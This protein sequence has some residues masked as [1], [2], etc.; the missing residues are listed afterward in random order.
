MVDGGDVV[1]LQNWDHLVAVVGA[2]NRLPSSP[3]D[4]DF[5]RVGEPHLS[6]LSRHL[7]QTVLLSDRTSPAFASLMRSC[8]NI[9]GGLFLRPTYT[10][11]L[12]QCVR[13]PGRSRVRH[14]MQRQPPT[15]NAAADAEARLAAFKATI[16]PDISA[17]GPAVDHTLIFV[18]SYFDYV[19]L[20][21]ALDAAGVEFVTACEYSEQRDVARAR[22]RFASGTSPILLVTERF[23]YF[24]R[25][26]I[27][28][29]RRLLF[30]GPPS[31]A[32]FYPQLVNGMEGGEGGTV[33]TLFSRWDAAALERVVGS[34][35]VGKLLDETG[36]E[37]FV[38]GV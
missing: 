28:G 21:N 38:M 15:P 24:H 9:S 8:A 12:D 13:Q 37:L 32:W 26:R 29:A 34:S 5:S 10:G 20:R 22:S 33:M 16:L 36:K 3:R 4:T 14:V 31:C 35:A 23:H 27:R 30:Y 1:A 2:C 19:R 7:R 17:G 18:P 6:G 25:L 11:T